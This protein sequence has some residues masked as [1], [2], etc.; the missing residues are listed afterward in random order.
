MMC[1]VCRLMFAACCPLVDVRW[2]LFV[3]CWLLLDVHRF[4]LF[5]V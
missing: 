4:V 2:V 3:A 1:L 5:V